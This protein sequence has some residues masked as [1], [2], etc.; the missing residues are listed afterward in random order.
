MVSVSSSASATDCEPIS[1]LTLL[2]AASIDMPDST[3]I[4]SRSSASGKA[5]LIESWRLAMRFFRN[6]YG[7]LHADI[8]GG[9]ANAD[10]DRRRLV[11]LEHHEQVE[12]RE[13]RTSRPA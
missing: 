1:S 13:Q 12:Q 11:E 9:E 2:N 10:L 4:S 7:S 3:Q 6:R 8:G 5:R